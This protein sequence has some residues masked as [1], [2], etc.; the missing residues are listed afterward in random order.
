MKIRNLLLCAI[1]LFTLNGCEELGIP[2][3]EK[4]AA[5]R[6]AEGEAIGSACRQTGRALEDCFARNPRA[7]K[8]AIFAGWGSMNDYMMENNIPTVPPPPDPAPE[9]E[10]PPAEDAMP[11]GGS[12][13]GGD[14]TWMVDRIKRHS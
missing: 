5:R 8:A 6:Q 13:S 4:E 1:V 11:T 3:P 12:R 2:D 14:H 10:A 9:H 7:P